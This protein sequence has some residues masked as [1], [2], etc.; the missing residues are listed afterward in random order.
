[1]PCEGSAVAVDFGVMTKGGRVRDIAVG[2]YLDLGHTYELL[3]SGYTLDLGSVELMA[4][5]V[6]Y[7]W[8]YVVTAVGKC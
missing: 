8:V 2:L 5:G 6:R 1:M 3:P 7:K 4:D